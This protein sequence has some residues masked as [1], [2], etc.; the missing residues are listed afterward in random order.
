MTALS[1]DA[2]RAANRERQ[3]EWPG[4][5]KA[6]VA[7]RAIEV[8]GEFGEVSEAVKKHLRA[9]R[10]IKGSTATIG[11]IAEEMADALIALDLLADE[12]GIGLGAAVARKFNLTSVKY[13]L[14]T[15]L[16]E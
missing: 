5:E 9:V 11:D 8:A 6:D 4:N 14:A 2:L 10:G 7:F 16:P 3:Q 15:R 1:F 12:L 13:E